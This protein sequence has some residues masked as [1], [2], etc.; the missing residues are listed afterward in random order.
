MMSKF[1]Y[2]IGFLLLISTYAQAKPK[3]T[4]ITNYSIDKFAQIKV[5]NETNKRLA[6]YVSIDGYKIRFR[7][8]ARRTSRWFKATDK[9][10]KPTSLSHWCDYLELYP[11]YK[12]YKAY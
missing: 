3:T 9:R 7:L 11:D 10:F 5:T 4:V 1:F 12:K 8:Q 2:F 6:C